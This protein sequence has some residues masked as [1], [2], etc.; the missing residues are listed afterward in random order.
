MKISV[1]GSLIDTEFIYD[2]SPVEPI[3]KMYSRERKTE[4][5]GL[6]QS[7]GFTIYF[8]NKK[9]LDV[10]LSTNDFKNNL[11]LY[12][13]D[14]EYIYSPVN[15]RVFETVNRS[16]E[17]SNTISLHMLNVL[18]DLRNRIADV[19]KKSQGN[20]PKFEFNTS[21]QQSTTI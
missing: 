1:L 17:L 21:L 12:K 5:E 7:A 19:W 4:Y 10:S 6:A 2:I 11:E 16:M 3:S 18:N 15:N 8:L 20:I 9:K 13:D 14:N